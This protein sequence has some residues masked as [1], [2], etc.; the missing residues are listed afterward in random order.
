M[1]Y[2]AFKH[3]SYTLTVADKEGNF[4]T[5]N[6]RTITSAADAAAAKPIVLEGLNNDAVKFK[7]EGLTEDEDNPENNTHAV[8]VVTLQ[9]QALDP[10]I[11]NMEIKCINIP[12]Q[13]QLAQ[14]FTA[15]NFR[16]SGGEFIFYVPDELDGLPVDIQFSDLY[17][18]YGDK[19]YWNETMSLTNSRYSFVTSSYFNPINGNGNLGLYDG[20]Y[21]P[22]ASYVNKVITSTA[23]NVRFKF[24]N[25]EDL[26]NSGTGSA[27]L[28]E[29]PFSV[30]T[31]LNNYPD[32]DAASGTTATI[33][34]FDKCTV[35]VGDGTQTFKSFFVF[36]ADETRWNIAPTTDWQ[37]RQYA[38]YRMDVKAVAKEYSPVLNWTKI[39]D[40]SLYSEEEGTEL[41]NSQWG[42]ELH[43]TEAGPTGGQGYLTVKQILDKID[44]AIAAENEN[45][46]GKAPTSKSQILYID[47]SDLMGIYNIV[48]EGVQE[49]NIED[50]KEGMGANVL[51]FLPENV[52]T[53]ASNF[54]YKSGSSFRAGNNFVLTDKHPFFSP[55]TIN[56]DAAKYATYTRKVTVSANGQVENATM[57]LPFTIDVN[58]S[59]EHANQDGKCTFTVNT[60]KATNSNMQA[61]NGNNVDYGTGYFT[62]ISTTK[63]VANKPYMI[64]VTD[65]DESLK[66]NG[67]VSFVITQY[68]SDIIATP[69]VGTEGV[70]EMEGESA[71]GSFGGKD[72]DFTNYGSY[73]GVKYDRADSEDIFY[74][75]R[76]MYLN[77]HTLNPSKQYLYSYPFRAVYKYA[78]KSSSGTGTTTGGAKLMRGFD[79]SYDDIPISG[80]AT[81]I[82]AQDTQADLIVKVGR[83]SVTM[84]ASRAQDVNIN[85]L[86][87]MNMKRVDLNAG[88]TKTVNLPA[89]IYVINNV[90]VIVK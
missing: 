88:D 59:G 34:K 8:V 66:G 56:V 19:T 44:A 32:P 33:A 75:A 31:Y 78:T 26:G 13:L 2:G 9:L 21:N 80:I 48:A 62:P 41:E 47:G 23:G 14:T 77:L 42:L 7:I 72:Y 29:Y 67:T 83:G 84:T 61:Q 36:T 38:F 71:T 40:T 85:T 35:T 64:H 70:K 60:M 73:S 43:T 24:N 50:L 3:G 54:A 86:N 45:K 27:Y 39:Y 63:T 11:N 30:K 76:D 57:I 58:N 69:K 25:A 17:S 55:F 79:I 22:N 52:T 5:D 90:K 18:N 89:G 53:T 15:S 46:T 12:K 20:A 4:G 65:I 28:E 74:F 82:A 68:G 51:I 1:R 49:T 6:V 81:D 37:H 10:Y 16:V 87:G